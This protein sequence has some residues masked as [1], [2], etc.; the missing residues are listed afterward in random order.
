M[1][2]PSPPDLTMIGIDPTYAPTLHLS[3]QRQPMLSES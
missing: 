1:Y 3:V 2:P